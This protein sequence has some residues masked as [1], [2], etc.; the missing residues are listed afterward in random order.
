MPGKRATGGGAPTNPDSQSSTTGGSQYGDDPFHVND[1]VV[2]DTKPV[3]Q[4]GGGADNTEYYEKVV[5]DPAS[6]LDSLASFVGAGLQVKAQQL[7]WSEYEIEN[8]WNALFGRN[9]QL[10]PFLDD[11]YASADKQASDW[12]N[13]TTN[14]ESQAWFGFTP[15]M[16]SQLQQMGANYY[17]D[18]NEG[19]ND[20]TNRV[21]SFL[22]ERTKVDLGA[23]PRA[24][25]Q[26]RGP[27]GGGGGPTGL[28]DEEIRNQ[29]DI[30][31]LAEMASG[32][33]RGMLLTDDVDSRG[34]AKA[35]VEAIVASKGEKK[36]DF[37]EYIR[38]KAMETSRYASIFSEKPDSESPEQYI[39]RFYGAA[40]QVT[41]PGAAA[42]VAIQGAQFGASAAD[43]ASRLQRTPEAQSS[44]PFISEM[45][46]RL[47]NLNSLFKG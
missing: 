29:F 28:T 35:Y 4:I 22:N 33:W 31:Q 6:L 12:A 15:D 14:A 40:S 39:S 21:W 26:P 13:F 32:I 20:L 46:N 24:D 43:F 10:Y 8:Q 42:D 11:I 18:T 9:S 5:F 30:D 41:S 25:L 37:T 27:G 7:G 44:A 3:Y 23:F 47:S 34:M 19:F 1:P 45:E 38:G 16:G 2:D 36:I 17:A